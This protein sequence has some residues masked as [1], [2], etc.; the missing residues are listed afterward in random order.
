MA[1][2][3]HACQE[4]F[5]EWFYGSTSGVCLFLADIF[6]ADTSVCMMATV[7]AYS[8]KKVKIGPAPF[9]CF[10]WVCSCD[11]FY[12][13]ETQFVLNVYQARPVSDLAGCVIEGTWR[14]RMGKKSQ[15]M[16]LDVMNVQ[17]TLH[18][19]VLAGPG[20]AAAR[21]PKPSKV[22]CMQSVWGRSG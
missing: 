12:D 21:R 17:L 7:F 22:M 14:G 9:F 4:G 5:A 1:I 10:L 8:G 13:D 20:N 3:L 6:G 19:P 18:G 16:Q 15:V 11:W 2:I